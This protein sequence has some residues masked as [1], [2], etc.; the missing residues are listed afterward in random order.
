MTNSIDDVGVGGPSIAPRSEINTF[1]SLPY[2][3][4]EI[5]REGVRD[6]VQRLLDLE[7]SKGGG[8]ASVSEARL[9]RRFEVFVQRPDLLERLE[10]IGG[11]GQG[12]DALDRNRYQLATPQNDTT[13]DAWE[14]SARNA[15]AQLMHSDYRSTNIELLKTYGANN[16]RLHNFQQEA[17]LRTLSAAREDIQSSVQDI[18]RKRKADQTAAGEELTRLKRRWAELLNRCLS[19]ELA[20]IV[21][22][23]EIE[24]NGKELASL[25]DRKAKAS[26]NS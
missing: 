2:F 10:Q 13:P 4:D 23:D 6:R 26:T 18:N 8:I 24:Q 16:W 15:E 14:S 9:P 25:H 21:A 1:E 17:M 22:R 19:V 11:R 20:N 5:D 3:D 7:M 12:T